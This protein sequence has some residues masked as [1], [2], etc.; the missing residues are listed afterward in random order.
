[1]LASLGYAISTGDAEA[2]PL[3]EVGS[4]LAGPAAGCAFPSV[5]VREHAPGRLRV[6]IEAAR[7][8]L[9]G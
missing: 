6:P 9:A 4:A 3:G 8:M 2:L 7:F 5:W 1:M